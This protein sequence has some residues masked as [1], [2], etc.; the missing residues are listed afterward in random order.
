M[1][2]ANRGLRFEVL[3]FAFGSPCQDI[4]THYKN[5]WEIEPWQPVGP[6]KLLI[7]PA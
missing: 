3:G 1:H 6:E 7:C 2:P 5:E 4:F